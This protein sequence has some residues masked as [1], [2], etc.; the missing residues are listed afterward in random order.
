MKVVV[1]MN[2]SVQ[3]AGYLRE[4]GHEAKHWMEI[5]SFDAADEEIIDYRRNDGAVILT[6]DL[7]FSTL[8]AVHG[9][10]KPSV[11][12]LRSK[13]RLPASAGPLVNRALTVGAGNLNLGAIV[14]I[15]AT[16]MCVAKLPICS[17]EPR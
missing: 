7:D 16:R 15:S 4:R 11:V 1:D 9:T 14:T 17:T 5:G 6:G 2:L 8:H 12:Q 10:N 3:W 13:D